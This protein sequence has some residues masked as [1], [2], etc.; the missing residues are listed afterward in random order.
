MAHVK[1][2][3]D[4][5]DRPRIDINGADFTNE[6]IAD[7]LRVVSSGGGEGSEVCVDLRIA[8]SRLDLGDAENVDAALLV[9]DALT[10]MAREVTR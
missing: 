1:L 3:R 5:E 7:T 4:Q 8:L 2:Y 9:G 10:S 6:V